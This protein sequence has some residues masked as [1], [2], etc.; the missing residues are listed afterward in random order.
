MLL[1]PQE[2]I[3]KDVSKGGTCF[4]NVE[5]WDQAHMLLDVQLTLREHKMLTIFLRHV[6]LSLLV[7]A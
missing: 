2:S 4:Q 3:E 1:Q 6:Y 7:L 5:Y